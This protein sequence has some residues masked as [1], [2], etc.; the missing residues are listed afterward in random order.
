LSP[1]GFGEENGQSLQHVSAQCE[2]LGRR[3]M[4]RPM[5]NLFGADE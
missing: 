5:N 4:S 3:R 2:R 1:P